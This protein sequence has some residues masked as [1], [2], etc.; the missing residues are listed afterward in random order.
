MNI[1]RFLV[2]AGGT[3]SLGLSAWGAIASLILDYRKPSELALALTFVAPFPLFLF[4][5]WSLR[6]SACA[7][8]VCNISLYV[9]RAFAIHPNP[10]YNPFDYFGM[11]FLSA[12]LFIVVAVFFAPK[13]QRRLNED[14]LWGYETCGTPR[15]PHS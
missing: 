14:F 12:P 15:V 8:F 7:L 5:I 3:V 10:Q 4:S 1:A 11:I 2:I 6:I 9:I 13:D